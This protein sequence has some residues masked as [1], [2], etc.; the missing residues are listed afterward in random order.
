MSSFG[1]RHPEEPGVFTPCRGFHAVP[2]VALP[3]H[4]DRP[5]SC[6]VHP[7]R[8]GPWR[9]SSRRPPNPQAT[10][11][12]CIR[13]RPGRACHKSLDQWN[14]LS[15]SQGQKSHEST[16]SNF[17]S[18]RKISRIGDF[19]GSLAA[20]LLIVADFPAANMWPQWVG[21]SPTPWSRHRG[22]S[23]PAVVNMGN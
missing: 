12:A 7:L 10:Q 21:F 14:F 13:R 4:N 19:G 20:E 2:G 18:S 6:A 15:A 11:T 5:P 9:R 16:D 8:R 22:P 3:V 1:G 23:P 17:R